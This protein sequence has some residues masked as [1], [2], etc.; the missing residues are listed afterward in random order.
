MCR[1]TKF[2]SPSL[3]ILPSYPFVFPNFPLRIIF[4]NSLSH[5]LISIFHFLNASYLP[6]NPFVLSVK[7]F[8]PS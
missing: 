5:F 6:I 8:S 3:S 7:F 4:E 2:H 1:V